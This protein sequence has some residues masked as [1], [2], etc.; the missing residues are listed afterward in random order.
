MKSIIIFQN[1][2]FIQE[3]KGD[4]SINLVELT[5]YMQQN[6]LQELPL[7]QLS[8]ESRTL[9]Q[10]KSLYLYLGWISDTLNKSGYDIKKVIK[11][12]VEWNTDTVKVLLW[13]PIQKAVTGEKSSANLTKEQFQNTQKYL[14][15]MLLEKFGVNVMFPDRRFKDV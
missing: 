3:I 6:N 9:Q 11:T 8:E 15:K 4:G 12:D 14:D 10:N 2:P 1:K 5:S 13:S 7:K